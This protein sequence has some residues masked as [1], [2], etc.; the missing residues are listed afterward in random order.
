MPK[1]LKT[2]VVMGKIKLD[3]DI[4]IS[5]ESLE[6]A[7]DKAKELNIHDFIQIKGGYNDGGSEV[8]GVF[9]SNNS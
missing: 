5:A 3:T 6:D 7:L 9:E 8:Y 2:F 1:R 4:E